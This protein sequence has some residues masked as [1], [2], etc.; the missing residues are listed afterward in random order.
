MVFPQTALVSLHRLP[1]V[2]AGALGSAM[3][4]VMAE[5]GAVF[6][7]VLETLPEW[8]LQGTSLVTMCQF[9]DFV[10]TVAFVDQLVA[11]AEALGHHPDLAIAYNQLTI[12]LTTHDA[13]GVTELD[14]NLA[15]DISTLSEGRCHP[16]S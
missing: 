12:S 16:P 4:V 15:R 14:F 9:E 11:P 1:I 8:S 13:G 5:A 2:L 6:A 7:S 3:A 10:D